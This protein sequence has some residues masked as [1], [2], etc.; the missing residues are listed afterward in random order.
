ML[1]GKPFGELC[2]YNCRSVCKNPS[3][4]SASAGPAVPTATSSA[5]NANGASSPSNSGAIAGGVA[6]GTVCVALAVALVMWWKRSSSNFKESERKLSEHEMTDMEAGRRNRLPNLTVSTSSGITPSS[7]KNSISE[8]AGVSNDETSILFSIYKRLS[9]ADTPAAKRRSSIGWS[10]SSSTIVFVENTITGLH[11][12]IKVG[13]DHVHLQQEFDTLEYLKQFDGYYNFLVEALDFV[14]PDEKG[15]SGIV[16]PAG[17]SNLRE[18]VTKNKDKMEPTKKLELSIRVLAICRFFHDCGLVWGD[19]KPENFVLFMQDDDLVLKGIDMD[20]AKILRND[21][22]WVSGQDQVTQCYVSPERWKAHLEKQQLE[23]TKEQDVFAAGLV[24]FFIWTG[25]DF[26]DQHANWE[27]LL[28]NPDEL[29]IELPQNLAAGYHRDVQKILKGMLEKMPEDR[30]SLNSILSQRSLLVNSIPSEAR[31]SRGVSPDLG[32]IEEKLDRLTQDQGKVLSKLTRMEQTLAKTFQLV[33]NDAVQIRPDEVPNFVLMLP[34]DEVAGKPTKITQKFGKT[35][36]TLLKKADL[37]LHFKLVVLDE[38]EKLLADYGIEAPSLDNIETKEPMHEGY[39]VTMPG[40]NLRRMAPFLNVMSQAIA[41]GAF[42]AKIGGI[43]IP[44]VIKTEVQALKDLGEAM[45]DFSEIWEGDLWQDSNFGMG[46]TMDAIKEKMD[47]IQ[48][49][50]EAHEDLEQL[51]KNQ[52]FKVVFGP[53]YQQL[54]ELLCPENQSSGFRSDLE[55]GKIVKLVDVTRSTTHFVS[56]A[57]F[58][59]HFASRK[60]KFAADRKFSS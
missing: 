7:S 26:F 39:D 43:T 2:Q 22:M 6:G 29:R 47:A 12:C 15:D 51:Q 48:G 50:V 18:Y 30:P 1:C 46:E 49:D 5:Q 4:T 41:V 45:G 25:R 56:K 11:N 3:P 52:N 19:I 23:A 37:K 57:N 44:P 59:L 38:T 27:E 16:M 34:Y 24:L 35:W 33:V 53:F 32:N 8:T 9:T 42:V 13:R 58:L 60:D 31:D 54:K 20:S 36:R 10:G 14:G 55:S 17:Q 40:R 21:K 28:F